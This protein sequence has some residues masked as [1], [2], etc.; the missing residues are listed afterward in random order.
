M[1][2]QK[3]FLLTETVNIVFKEWFYCIEEKGISLYYNENL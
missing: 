1:I 3:K 2:R